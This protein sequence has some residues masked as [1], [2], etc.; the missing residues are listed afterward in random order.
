M[1]AGL[2]LG[3]L[4]PQG[5]YLFL[6]SS[7]GFS[8]LFTYAIIMASHYRLRKQH[9]GPFSEQHGMRG[10]PYT[11]WFTIGSLIAIIVSMPLIPG[12]GG[13]LAAGIM[14]VVLF[15]GLYAWGHY[16]KPSVVTP[17]PTVHLPAIS[18]FTGVALTEMSEELTESKDLDKGN[19]PR[20]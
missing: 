1:L 16:R 20:K 5:V 8:V 3:M 18:P 2:G 7:G 19:E 13:G 10:Y 11:S 4:L 14:F 9:G 12:Q 15:A 6:V 17:K